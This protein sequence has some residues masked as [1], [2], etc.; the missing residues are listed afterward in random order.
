MTRQFAPNRGGEALKEALDMSIATSTS[1]EIMTRIC[2]R[3][4]TRL[5]I[6]DFARSAKGR[7]GRSTVCPKCTEGAK[8]EARARRAEERARH[9]SMRVVEKAVTEAREE[10][11]REQIAIKSAADA[12]NDAAWAAR[13]TPAVRKELFDAAETVDKLDPPIPGFIYLI[14]NSRFPNWV[15]VGRSARIVERLQD[16][17]ASMPTE[18]ADLFT[19]HGLSRCASIQTQA[20][21]R[22]CSR[23]LSKSTAT[24]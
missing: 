2:S 11:V 13:T 24:A 7:G 1:D 22:H 19:L 10:A 14:G 20:T 4:S 23:S 15:K 8:V 16:Y 5:N 3:C 21:A 17:R 18:H 12:A 9:A 6:G